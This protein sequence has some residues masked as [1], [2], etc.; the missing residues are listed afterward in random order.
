MHIQEVV[1]F[2]LVKGDSFLAEKRKMTKKVLPGALV[3]PVGKVL[4]NESIE[5]AMLREANEE[6]GIVPK[7]YKL[8]CMLRNK[9]PDHISNI[10]YYFISAWD[11]EIVCKEAEKLHWI[12]IIELNRLTLEVDQIAITE[13]LRTREYPY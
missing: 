6:L 5:Q 8:V 10:H 11:N 1:V 2:V 7:H 13:F 9:Y 3:T 12:P 4:E